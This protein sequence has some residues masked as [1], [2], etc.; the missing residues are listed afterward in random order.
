MDG[1]RQS[2]RDLL[3][4]KDDTAVTDPAVASSVN[5]TLK[6]MLSKL[7]SG[8]VSSLTHAGTAVSTTNPLPVIGDAGFP[9]ATFTRPDNATP[10]SIGDVVGTDAAANRSFANVLAVAGGKFIILGVKMRIDA[11]AIPA[12]MTSF[13]L[14][15]YDAAPTA[16][17][18]NVAFNLPSADRAI[19]LGYITFDTGLDL[20]DTVWY[21]NDNVNFAGKLAAASTTLY[22]QMETVTAFTPTNL[23]VKTIWLTVMGA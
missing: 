11:A 22:A 13:R 18:D 7:A 23:C 15:F 19:Y 2:M 3:G 12:G 21:Q 1:W 9:S 4:E 6:G 10:Y 5:A 20:G 14:H 16:I 17:T 8:I